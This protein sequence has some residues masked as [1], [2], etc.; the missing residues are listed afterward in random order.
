LKNI[1]KW[2]K[3]VCFDNKR[4]ELINGEVIEMSTMAQPHALCVMKAERVLHRL[5]DDSFFVRTQ[6]PLALA[7]LTEPEPGFALVTGTLED[8]AAAHPSTAELVIEVSDSTLRYDRTV[9]ASLYAG[10]GIAEYWIL[11][12]PQNRLERFREPVADSAQPHDFAYNLMDTLGPEGELSPQCAP[13]VFLRVGD[14][15]P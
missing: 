8:F 4:V 9:K 3:P 1:T 11:N 6:L 10:A 14:L 15:L 13:E 2:E 5:F 12:L 7:N